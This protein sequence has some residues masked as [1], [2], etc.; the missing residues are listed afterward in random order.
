MDRDQHIYRVRMVKLA[1]DGAM[2]TFQRGRLGRIGNRKCL[3][4][5]SRLVL[6]VLLKLGYY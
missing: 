6:I 1:A 3:L 4:F 5:S 2:Q